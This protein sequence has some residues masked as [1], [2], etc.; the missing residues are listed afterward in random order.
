MTEKKQRPL[1][2][3]T[4]SSQKKGLAYY[5]LQLALLLGGARGVLLQPHHPQHGLKIDGLILTGGEDVHPSF[6]EHAL[7]PNYAY[8]LERDEMEFAWLKYAEEH[9]L[10]VLGICRGS[11]LI[12]IYRKGTLHFE[13]HKA[14]E[15]AQYPSSLLAKIFYRKRMNLQ[16][17]TL[18]YKIY[19]EDKIKVNS[20]HTQAID[21]LGHHLVITASEGNG[22][23]QA[24]ED[25]NRRFFLGVQYHPE[26]LIYSGRHRKIFREFIKAINNP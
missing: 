17:G 23:V 20:I 22:V 19:Q 6:Y 14:Y 3:I 15:K 9:N 1:I 13:V 2:G 25:P 11:Q 24:V 12:N 4:R 7:K 5:A 10:P 16:K 8:S 21:K 26:Y 18:I